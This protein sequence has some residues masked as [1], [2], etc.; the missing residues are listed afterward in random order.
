MGCEVLINLSIFLYVIAFNA[1]FLLGSGMLADYQAIFAYP[2]NLPF[3][4]AVL[5]FVTAVVD[6][7]YFTQTGGDE[8]ILL[9]LDLG[10]WVLDYC[11]RLCLLFFSMHRL[12]T[13]VHPKLLM[14][15]VS[16]AT[17]ISLGS[18][19]FLI[20]AASTDNAYSMEETA[21]SIYTATDLL[22]LSLDFYLAYLVSGVGRRRQGY[23]K[24]IHE[25]LFGPGFSIILGS[26]SCLCSFTVTKMNLD[27][28][29]IYYTYLFILRIFMLQIFNVRLVIN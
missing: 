17:M 28:N 3:V 20:Y 7:G 10:S 23:L 19:T 27:P 9:A 24:R 14:Y 21:L 16:V 26:A 5:F 22:T 1:M 18:F 29:Y 11:S 13:L 15:Y 6:Y 2:H 12:K 8:A 4:A 25:L